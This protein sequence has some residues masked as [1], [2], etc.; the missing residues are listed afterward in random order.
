MNRLPPLNG[1]KA[2]EAAARHTS[3][4]LAAEE[5]NVTP[6]AISHQVK[7]LEAFLGVTLFVRRP[8]GLTL[9]DAGRAYV[10]GLTAGFETL[11]QAGNRLSEKN[12]RG[13]LTLSVLPSF[14]NVWLVPRLPRFMERH[15][16]LSV[17]VFYGESSVDF[18]KDPIDIGI[19][20]GLGN[21]PGLHS[22]LIM[23]E[24]VY[25]VCSPMLMNGAQ[26]LNKFSDLRYFPLIHDCAAIDVE[27][28]NTWAFWLAQEGVKD[29]DATSGLGISD[30][31]A[32]L[33]LVVSG[34]GVGLGRSSLTRDHLAAGRLVR[35]FDVSRPTEFSHFAVAPKASLEEPK[36][37]AFFDWILEEV[38]R[39]GN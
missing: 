7:G 10:P 28:S 19:R 16:E 5:L 36:V 26:P 3:F 8:R 35:P 14:G 31:V 37:K 23:T 12:V 11:L 18:R 27:V 13:R 4:K 32:L 1:L 24:E 30:S 29:V 38:T 17:D 22:E 15:P 34:Y 6:A 33:D 39:D 2:F 21:Y 20:Y 25:P 9:T